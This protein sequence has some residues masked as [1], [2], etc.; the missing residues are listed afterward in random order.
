MPIAI[1][2]EKRI[3]YVLRCERDAESPTIFELK[4]LTVRDM[5]AIRDVRMTVS[6]DGVTT[7]R[8]GSE[9]LVTLKAGLVGWRNFKDAA[10]KDVVFTR[11]GG[12]ASDET[13]SRLAPEWR[14]ELSDEIQAINTLTADEKKA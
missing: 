7:F 11:E 2:P 14:T 4:A 1:D 3:E 12:K 8:Q 9:E 13:L 10:G 5:T 6:R